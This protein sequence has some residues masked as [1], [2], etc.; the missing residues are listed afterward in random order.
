MK[1]VLFIASACSL[2][3]VG[4]RFAQAE[5]P[6]A[7]GADALAVKDSDGSASLRAKK[8]LTKMEPDM[9]LIKVDAVDDS[10]FPMCTL[11]GTIVKEATATDKHFKLMARNKKYT[12]RPVLKMKRKDVDLKD[13]MTQNNLGACYYPPKS[14]LVIK[15]SGVDL[16]AKVFDAAEIYLK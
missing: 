11:T 4:I 6:F 5:D 7:A 3:Y 2:L 1:K 14:T 9:I 15:V 12:F 10:K 13:E 16:K 8:K